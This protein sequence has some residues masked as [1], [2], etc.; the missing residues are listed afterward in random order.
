ME[1]HHANQDPAGHTLST[2]GRSTGSDASTFTLAELRPETLSS[3]LT[4]FATI[5][6]GFV[7][8]LETLSMTVDEYERQLALNEPTIVTTDNTVG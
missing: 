1:H 7:A 3:V 4:Q 6:P 8:E 5:D 2:D